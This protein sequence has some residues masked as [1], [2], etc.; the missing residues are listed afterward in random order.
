M[1]QWLPSSLILTPMRSPSPLNPDSPVTD[2]RQINTTWTRDENTLADSL[3]RFPQHREVPSICDTESKLLSRHP[4]E[5]NPNPNAMEG[6][7]EEQWEGLDCTEASYREEQTEL[8]LRARNRKAPASCIS[9][10]RICSQESQRVVI[11]SVPSQLGSNTNDRA[12]P[13]PRACQRTAIKTPGDS[14]RSLRNA[15]EAPGGSKGF[16]NTAV[17][18]PPCPPSSIRQTETWPS[19]NTTAPRQTIWMS[20]T[21]AVGP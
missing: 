3:T 7:Q 16:Y 2:P 17:S 20:T 18:H 6:G 1:A 13:D 9:T 14:V 10:L 15:V 8:S 19:A 21:P 11:Q 5:G 4:M 12:L